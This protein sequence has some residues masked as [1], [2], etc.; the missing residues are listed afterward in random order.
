M[1]IEKKNLPKSIVE[2]IIEAD[3]KEVA[4]QRKRVFE[5]LR[6]NGDIKGFRKGANVPDDVLEKNYGPDHINQMTVE[7]TIDVLYKETLKKEKL[8]PVAQAEIK[9][10]ISQ[11]PLKIRMHV[12]V[13]PEIT[14]KPAYKKIK[15]TKK[16]VSVS[17]SE[18][19]AALDDIQTRFTHFHEV[20]DKKKKAAM[21]DKLTIDTDGHDSK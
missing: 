6:K 10:I 21:G 14:I 11:E 18:V 2:Y 16:K 3:A 7:Y 19:Q 5:Y 9:E 8:V 17:A 12:E 4:K 13:L 15:L 20:E 1:K